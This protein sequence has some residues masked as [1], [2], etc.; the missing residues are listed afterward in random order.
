MMFIGGLII[1]L[2]VRRQLI[3]FVNQIKISLNYILF[4]LYLE[5]HDDPSR[6][7]DRTLDI[8]S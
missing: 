8:G 4:T 7:H 6:Q 2:A 3:N 1:A 5:S